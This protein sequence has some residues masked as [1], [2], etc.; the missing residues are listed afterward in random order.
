MTK[1]VCSEREV[2]ELNREIVNRLLKGAPGEEETSVILW[3]NKRV[4]GR[5]DKLKIR[6]KTPWSL[7]EAL[8]QFNDL[9]LA[10]SYIYG[11]IDLEGDIF[12]LFP[13]VDWILQR[14]WP[15]SE[16]VKLWRLIRRLPGEAQIK[17]CWAEVDGE[18]HSIERDKQA[19]QYHYDVSNDFYRLFLD[20]N[21]VYSC[22]YFRTPHDSLDRAQEQKIDYIC[23]KLMLKPGERFLDIGCGWG[24]LIIHAA[25][26]YGVYA[27]GIT[28]SENQYRY[29]KERI[30]E[31]GLEGRCEVLLADYR[32]L[33]EPESFD[34]I[35]SV[36]MFEHVG[37]KRALTYFKQAYN[38]L[39][40]KGIFLNHAISCN[41]HEFGKPASQFIRKYVFPDGELLPIYLTVEKAEEAGFEVRDVECLREH[42]TLTLMHWVRNLERNYKKAVEIAGE[43]R[44]RIWRLY[45][46]SSAYQFLTNRI[47]LYQTLLV[48]TAK[49]GSSGFPLTREHL[50]REG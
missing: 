25:K 32:E 13:L 15:L 6:I 34:K 9:S 37:Q 18:L 36:G 19:I 17:R 3:N 1:E 43:E 50:Y 35:A 31:E 48:K 45:M 16:K 46:A 2:E 7:K 20:R 14:R 23:R 39:K 29:V 30:K 8:K 11:L 10:E 38:L 49:D 41:Y 44:Y 40:E 42:Y 26:K 28:L 47:G 22:G 21:M 12:L 27:L 24:A 5:G 33:N 4:W